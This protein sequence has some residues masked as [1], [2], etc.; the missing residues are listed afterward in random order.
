M[1]R[2]A[3]RGRRGRCGR[4]AEAVP[5]DPARRGAGSRYL[6]RREAEAAA[7]MYR[8]DSLRETRPS[9][10]RHESENAIQIES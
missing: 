9:S 3:G 7:A 2:A 8:T 10:K 6:L 1:V 4:R 5:R